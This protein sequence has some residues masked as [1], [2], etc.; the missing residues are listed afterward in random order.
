[1]KHLDRSSLMNR[2][3]SESNRNCEFRLPGWAGPAVM[4]FAF[5][6]AACNYPV[7]DPTAT[8]AELELSQIEAMVGATLVA[9]GELTQAAAATAAVNPSPVSTAGAGDEA[10]AAPTASPSALPT[11]TATSPPTG[12]PTPTSTNT[13]KPSN[14]PQP[15]DTPKPTK[16]PVPSATICAQLELNAFRASAGGIG[17]QIS[18]TWDSSGGCLPI[19][20]SID[21][22]YEGDDQSFP[23]L[24]ISGNSGKAISQPPVK[25]EGTFVIVYRLVLQDQLGATVSAET[26]TEVTWKCG[27]PTPEK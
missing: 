23:P 9:E 8:P 5:A 17:N 6:L 18:L 11:D 4:A 3:S 7:S 20:G 26:K 2:L 15:S 22:A 1:M 14:T 13:P 12:T 16:T 19:E 27:S 21:G 24:K 25:C 10:Q